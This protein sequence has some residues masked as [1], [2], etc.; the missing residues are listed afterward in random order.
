MT[1]ALLE[2][3]ITTELPLAQ[4]SQLIGA[5]LEGQEGAS[6]TVK[7]NGVAATYPVTLSE[8][9]TLRIERP[10]GEIVTRLYGQPA[11]GQADQLL[12]FRG[13]V[14]T[15]ASLPA[16][17]TPGDTYTAADT[18]HLHTW[19]GAAW[20]DN[21]SVGI[22]GPVGPIGPQGAK[23]DPGVDSTVPGPQG[24]T[25][26][27]G[28]KGDPGPTGA[29][30]AAATVTVGSVTT[31]APGAQATVTNTGTESAAVL[32]FGIPKGADGAGGSGAVSSVAGRTGDVTL[33][34]ADV[35]LGNVTNDAQVKR[36]EMGVASGVATLGTDGKVLAAQLP[37][38]TGGATDTEAVQ[39]IV[40]AM[41]K[42]GSNTTVTYDD[43][44]N[45]LTISATSGGTNTPIYLS[46]GNAIGPRTPAT[47]PTTGDPANLYAAIWEMTPEAEFTLLGLR[48]LAV[49]G[50]SQYQ[51]VVWQKGVT[52]APL[53]TGSTITGGGPAAA[54]SARPCCWQEA[55]LT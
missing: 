29:A 49:L 14:D 30:G 6:A 12:T 25:G 15:A 53:A 16:N 44:A 24:P 55:R 32:N 5:V 43:A 22:P 33:T 48:D 54:R 3:L 36:S 20:V 42:A 39:D 40:G 7:V 21:G 11:P 31:L 52:A 27:K 2:T 26:P 19:D 38:G 47:V 28:D 9:D 23:G 4:H 37:A 17:A 35:D 50:Q 1:T 10:I 46:A 34:P 13:Q 51:A 45:T 18:D 8:S 41:V